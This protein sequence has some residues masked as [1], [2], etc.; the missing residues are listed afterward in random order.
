MQINY[1]SKADY[2]MALEGAKKLVAQKYAIIEARLVAT[3]AAGEL[4]SDE[5][6]TEFLTWQL[7]SV[8]VRNQE[9]FYNPEDLE[10]DDE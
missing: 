7:L 9:V 8:L 10:E 1:N 5:L 4:I 2:I 6:Y 3:K